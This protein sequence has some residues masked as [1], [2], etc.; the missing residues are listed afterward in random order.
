MA[1]E[2][3]AS[4][5]K[6]LLVGLVALVGVGVAGGGYLLWNHFFAPPPT[7]SRINMT[8]VASAGK[9]QSAETEQ[10][11]QLLSEYNTEGAQSAK[12]DN[13][14]FIASIPVGG[15]T[16]VHT[17]EEPPKE[18]KRRPPRQEK[19][20]EKKKD[21]GLSKSDQAALK[22][23]LA[24]IDATNQPADMQRTSLVV[25]T[26][27]GATGEGSTGGGK[28]QSTYAGWTSSVMP[29]TASWSSPG[30]TETSAPTIELIPA[31]TRVPGSV[32]FG[33]D[34]D[35]NNSPAV[36]RIYSG[37]YKGAVLKA[38]QAK[39]GGDGVVIHMTTMYWNRKNYRVDAYALK[40]DTLM[41]NVATDVT[42]HY[43]SR[44]LLPSIA[45]GIGKAGDLYADANTEILTNGYNTVTSHAGMP[46]GTAVAGVVAGGAASNA[47][48]VLKTDAARI[49]PTQVTVDAGQAVYVQFVAAV[50]TAD[51][52]KPRGQN[53]ADNTVV[54]RASLK[55]DETGNG[56][57]PVSPSISQLREQT[58]AR[59]RSQSKAQN[60]SE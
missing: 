47:A 41:A 9:R 15:G 23:I 54:T 4:R 29:Q 39:L 19:Q 10:Y 24:S 60:T 51:E 42:H 22:K 18:K 55:D 56:L 26:E 13:S 36:V 44:I 53:N 28:N 30:R 50:T 57:S 58:Q 37:P 43:G 17:V 7:P 59:I 21:D 11:R 16:P 40:D 33:I 49:S 52:I 1:N 5:D 38:D 31:Y 3:D 6:K 46:N 20:Q 8:N 34:S 12:S 35:N 14:S 48:D 25:A 27:P 45:A 32:E 2:H